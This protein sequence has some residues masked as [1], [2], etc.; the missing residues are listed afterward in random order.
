[1]ALEAS[2]KQAAESFSKEINQTLTND[3]LKEVYGL[4]K[5]VL[6]RA[7]MMMW[8]LTLI[9]IR[10]VTIA[11]QASEGDCNTARPGMLDLKGKAKWDSWNSKKGMTK[12]VLIL[13]K[14][15]TEYKESNVSGK[16]SVAWD[17]V[18]V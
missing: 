18:V 14:V 13:D 11:T 1:M 17:K 2:F 15:S 6:S 12:W 7:L 9:I 10:M 3:D 16:E 8:N 5:Q 4:Y